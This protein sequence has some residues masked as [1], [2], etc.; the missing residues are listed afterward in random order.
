MCE[1]NKRRLI[2]FIGVP[3]EIKFYFDETFFHLLTIIEHIF[4]HWACLMIIF[5]YLMNIN[6]TVWYVSVHR[7][8]PFWSNMQ[9]P[10]ETDRIGTVRFSTKIIKSVLFFWTV[11]ISFCS[12]HVNKWTVHVSKIFW[13]NNR[14]RSEPLKKNR[15][16][17]SP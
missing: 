15:S 5:C 7:T 10:F 4:I 14:I 3:D 1:L 17:Y 13:E 6:L 8:V 9:S 12:A 16:E 11:S 2:M